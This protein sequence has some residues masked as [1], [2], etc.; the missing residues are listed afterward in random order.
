M[1]KEPVYSRKRNRDSNCSLTCILKTVR[2]RI[3]DSSPTNFYIVFIWNAQFKPLIDTIINN[4]VT[5]LLNLEEIPMAK[6]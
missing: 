5:Y 4:Q 3:E 1:K 2:D 6:A